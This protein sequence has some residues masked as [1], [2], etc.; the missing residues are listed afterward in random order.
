MPGTID[1]KERRFIPALRFRA[2]TRFY[3]PVVA[4]TVR[5]RNFK[6]RLIAQAELDGPLDV[7]DLACGTGTLTLRAKRAAPQIR[8]T[9]IDAD[10]EVLARAET[11]ARGAGIIFDEGL[12]TDLPYPDDAFDRVISSLF[13]HHLEDDEKRRTLREVVR[14]LR[15]GGRLDVADWGKPGDLVMSVL[16]LSIRA[17]DGFAPTH[18]N[19]SGRL[20]SLFAEAGLTDVRT[21]SNLRTPYGTLCLYSARL[22]RALEA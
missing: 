2:L 12:S 14:V 21:R 10:P 1:V 5:E 3:D 4:L 6:S 8:I 22:P 18:A 20:P 17:L 15:P 7:L 9:G 16:S 19:F 11:K 13:F